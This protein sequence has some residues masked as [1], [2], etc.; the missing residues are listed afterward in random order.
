MD[1]ND[2]PIACLHTLLTMLGG[3]PSIPD[4][5]VGFSSV[6]ETIKVCGSCLCRLRKKSI[7]SG[8]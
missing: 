1:A 4:L 7:Q 5:E 6:R 3:G 2:K 8:F